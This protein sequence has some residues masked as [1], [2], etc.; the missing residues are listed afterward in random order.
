MR[1]QPGTYKK[2]TLFASRKGQILKDKHVCCN[3][4]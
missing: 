3:D 1:N 2:E 4:I